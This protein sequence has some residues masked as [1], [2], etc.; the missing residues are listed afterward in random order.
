M[1]LKFLS[2]SGSLKDAGFVPSGNKTL[3][4]KVKAILEI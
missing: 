1:C 4:K 3:S 2:Y